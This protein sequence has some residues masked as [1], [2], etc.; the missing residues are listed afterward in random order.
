[1]VTTEGGGRT[2]VHMLACM[3]VRVY[4]QYCYTETAH[5]ELQE[6]CLLVTTG[7][8]ET[9]RRGT[10][11]AQ[12]NKKNMCMYVCKRVCMYVCMRV[13]MYVCMYVCM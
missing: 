6:I 1:M 7:H 9:A 13:C 3:R 4:I 5:P 12:S 2:Y 8:P 10:K 11:D